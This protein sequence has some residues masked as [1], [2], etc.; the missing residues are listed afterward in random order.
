MNA[1]YEYMPKPISK[2]CSGGL[3]DYPHLHKEVEIIFVEKGSTVAFADKKAYHISDG[4]LYIS[5]PNQIHYYLDSM[6]GRYHIF[7]VR[8]SVFFGVR[9]V[10][11]SSVPE[12]NVIHLEAGDRAV[13]FLKKASATDLEADI[14]GVV[15]HLN[16]LMSEIMPRLVLKPIIQT[17]NSTLLGVLDFCATHFKEELTLEYVAERVHLS[18]CYISHLLNEK[19]GLGF[20]DYVNMLRV[21]EACDLLLQSDGRI[22]DIS[23]EVGFGSIRSFNRAFLRVTG[24]T[25]QEYRASAK[26]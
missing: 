6:Q 4:D 1:N 19:V 8:S 2:H 9:D 20:S 3:V 26:R 17:D 12:N 5:F 10:I 25:P 24:K 11:N 16:L 22:A 15:G 23:G 18:R 14:S 21:R 13:E 7:V